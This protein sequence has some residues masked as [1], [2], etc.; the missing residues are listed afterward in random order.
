MQVDKENF[1]SLKDPAF[2]D[3]LGI[4]SASEIFSPNPTCMANVK[5]GLGTI[6]TPKM[7]VRRKENL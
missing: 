7:T 4:S 1:R 3:T 5:D 2:A 6:G